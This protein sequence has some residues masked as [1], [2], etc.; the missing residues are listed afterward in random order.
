MHA[1]I[2]LEIA[3]RPD[4]SLPDRLLQLAY[5]ASQ[6]GRVI[7]LLD[8]IS[9]FEVDAA[10]DPLV[11]QLPLDIPG[12]V[13][14][15]EL[16]DPILSEVAEQAPLVFLSSTAARRHPALHRATRSRCA[17]LRAAAPILERMGRP[18]SLRELTDRSQCTGN[19]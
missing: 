11:H 17:T 7:L 2:L 18:T 16:D 5:R 12:V 3:R 8:G 9:P 4:G 14:H 13:Y 10:L 1:F 6:R 15:E 19:T